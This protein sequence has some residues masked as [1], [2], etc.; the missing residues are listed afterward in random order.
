MTRPNSPVDLNFANE[1]SG[2]KPLPLDAKAPLPTDSYIPNTPGLHA[3]DVYDTTLPWWR[4]AVRSKLAK[5]VEWESGIIADMQVSFGKSFTATF[6][7]FSSP[8]QKALSQD[9]M[10]GFLLCLHVF[11]GN[12]YIFH[13]ISTLM[14]FLWLRPARSGVRETYSIAYD[15]S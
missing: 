15:S 12:P 6:S 2:Q 3:Q 9:T 1:T 4:A 10:A 8:G 7:L 5:S 11:F 14:L 13:D